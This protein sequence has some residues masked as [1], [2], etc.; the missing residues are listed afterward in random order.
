MIA[1]KISFL[2]LVKENAVVMAMVHIPN[3]FVKEMQIV[4]KSIA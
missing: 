1:L 4:T 3:T 2:R